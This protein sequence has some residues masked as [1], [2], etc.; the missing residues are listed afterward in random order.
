MIWTHR[1]AIE[2][3]GAL[4][5]L[6]IYFFA[7]YRAPGYEAA[8]VVI[9]SLLFVVW[10]FWKARVVEKAGKPWSEW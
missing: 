10:C 9:F 5:F 1:N 7:H 3:V 2:S 6:A 8:V 4:L